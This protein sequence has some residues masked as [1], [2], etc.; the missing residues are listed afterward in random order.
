LSP[1]GKTVAVGSNNGKMSLW[2]VK[3]RKAI[4]RWTGHTH[5]VGALSWSTDGNQVL[6]GSWDGTARVWDVKSGKIVQ[7]LQKLRPVDATRMQSRSGM[8][9]QANC[10]RHSNMIG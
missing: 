5:V 9:R 7:M 6:S 3:T 1:D 2:N 4:A 10:S 8:Q